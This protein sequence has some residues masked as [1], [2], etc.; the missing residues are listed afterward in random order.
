LNPYPEKNQTEN[1]NFE[2]PNKKSSISQLLFFEARFIPILRQGPVFN[3]TYEE[4]ILEN[5]TQPD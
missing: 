1:P 5:Q 2:K 3:P 4:F